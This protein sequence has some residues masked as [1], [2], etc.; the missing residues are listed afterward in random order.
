MSAHSPYR[1]RSLSRGLRV[2][3]ALNARG[4]ATLAQLTTDTGIAKPTTFRI[5]KTLEEEEF[6]YKD[7]DTDSYR[8]AA[9]VASLSS[10]FEENAWFVEHTEGFLE[11]LSD[12]LVWPLSISTLAGTRILVRGNTD[13][14]SALAVRRL[15]PGMTLPILESASGRVLLAFSSTDTREKILERLRQSKENCDL[16]ARDTQRT[17]AMVS[18]ARKLGYATVTVPRRISDLTTLAVPVNVHE[19]AVA[20]LAIRFSATGVAQETV[21]KDFLPAMRQCAT[22]IGQAI[23]GDERAARVFG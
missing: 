23:A 10:G 9:R 2:L 20:A 12:Q 17:E 8:P 18:E 1:V 22:S 3:S 21:V 7:E 11:K 14:K 5:L 13:S 15:A 19:I 16:V 4:S 6:V